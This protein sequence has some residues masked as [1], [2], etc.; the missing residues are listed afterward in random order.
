MAEP[1]RPLSRLTRNG[2]RTNYFYDTGNGIQSNREKYC[3][4]M[5][6]VIFIFLTF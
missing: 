1:E 6:V 3:R 4:Q 5:L 2:G